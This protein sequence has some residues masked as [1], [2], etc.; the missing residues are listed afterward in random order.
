MIQ[1]LIRNN[2][3]DQ[4]KL[5]W[6]V[7]SLFGINKVEFLP[8]GGHD[9]A[10][11]KMTIVENDRNVN[12][13]ALSQTITLTSGKQYTI[14]YYVKRTLDVTPCLH[15]S[16]VNGDVM[17]GI[18]VTSQTSI[19][20]FEKVSFRFTVP[21]NSTAQLNAIFFFE[22]KVSSSTHSGNVW[23]DSIQLLDEPDDLT[24]EYNPEKYIETNLGARI[25]KSPDPTN[26]DNYGTVKSGCLFVYNGI[27]KNMVS[28]SYGNKYGESINAYICKKDC[29]SST[30]D[31]ESNYIDRMRTISQSLLGLDGTALGLG[32]DYCENF[33]HWLVGATG[34][35]QSL[36]KYF[37]F[38]SEKCGPSLKYYISNGNA[39]DL[40]DGISH[41]DIQAGDL[42]YYDVKNYGTDQMTAAHV[43]F[44]T[45]LKDGDENTFYSVE[46]NI[47]EKA[48]IEKCTGNCTT[49]KVDKH[50]RTVS[51]AVRPFG[52]G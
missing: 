13:V 49:G 8:N 12:N 43:G 37:Y 20:G 42:L 27:E 2:S 40:L 35:S 44:V 19:N 39:V 25:F 34:E 15:I 51:I 17:H 4:G 7:T 9:G 1:N 47:G 31:L 18:P 11:A 6:T 30:V 26:D 46:G 3:F 5:Y 29:Y 21:Q 33:I 50:N 36:S 14:S 24:G 22:G 32:G 48:T 41:A 45:G 52:N 10:C 16:F 23:I 38:G 28:I